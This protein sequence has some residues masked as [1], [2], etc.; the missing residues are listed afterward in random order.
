MLPETASDSF[1]IYDEY[2]QRDFFVV[3]QPPD[4][5]QELQSPHEG[6]RQKLWWAVIIDTFFVRDAA[7]QGSKGGSAPV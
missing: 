1:P 6:P 4:V 7:H 3:Q 5:T 2:G